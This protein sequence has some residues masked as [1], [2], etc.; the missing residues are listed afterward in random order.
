M[1]KSD[2][3]QIQWPGK[4]WTR[5]IRSSVI[6]LGLEVKIQMLEFRYL[7]MASAHLNFTSPHG[8]LGLCLLHY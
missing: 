5:W 2:F 6:E 4:R 8:Q 3:Q 7:A 1:E